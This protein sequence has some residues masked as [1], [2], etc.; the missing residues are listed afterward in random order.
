MWIKSLFRS[1]PPADYGDTARQRQI[2]VRFL[3]DRISKEESSREQEKEESRQEKGKTIKEKKNAQQEED[4]QA[5][6]LRT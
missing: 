5:G 2:G 4:K 6:K 1:E 3:H